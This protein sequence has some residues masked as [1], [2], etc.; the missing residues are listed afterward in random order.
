MELPCYVDDDE[1]GDEEQLDEAAAAAAVEAVHDDNA[2]EEEVSSYILRTLPLQ[3]SVRQ[4]RSRGL[5][6]QIWPAAS[7]LCTFL[8]DIFALTG[9]EL[10]CLQ[11]F[12]ASGT[13]RSSR[14]RGETSIIHA[15][16]DD[17]T[18]VNS[19]PCDGIHGDSSVHDDEKKTARIRTLELGAGTGMVGILSALLGADATITDLPHVIP[20]LLHNAS[21]NAEALKDSGRG[22]TINVQ[23]L[24]WGEQE[25]LQA[26]GRSFD[27]IL[28]SDVV[29]YDHLFEPLLQTL[30]WFLV[31]GKKYEEKGLP[32]DPKKSVCAEVRTPLVLL[33]HLRR[34]KKDAH[35]FRKASKLFRVRVVHTH[36]HHGNSRKGVTIYCLTSKNLSWSPLS[37]IWPPLK[38]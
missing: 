37:R 36:S 5:S 15:L 38:L 14:F 8:D 35:F 31:E 28:A 10:S 11:D 33:A 4:L 12:C 32:A 21:L 6:F 27:L 30:K 34:W 17:E 2:E 19:P 22:G 16:P 24:R 3:L 26:I 25:D 7:A 9:M 18:Q 23:T 13:L 29:Y 1:E 20:N